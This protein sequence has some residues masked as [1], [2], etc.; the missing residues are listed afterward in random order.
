MFN[1][2]NIEHPTFVKTFLVI[3]CLVFPGVA[4]IFVIDPKLFMGLDWIKL[5]LL[6]ASIMMP[7]SLF[8][9]AIFWAI[10][11]QNQD[12]KDLFSEFSIGTLMTGVMI[13]LSIA[14]YYV[15]VRKGLD[16]FLWVAF[17]AEITMIAAVYLE[18]KKEKKK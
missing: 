17:L 3:A 16:S 1:L 11:G 13:A 8:N 6:A 9:T 10:G 18:T 15:F 12:P 4:T 2:K 5:V 14:Y 7:I